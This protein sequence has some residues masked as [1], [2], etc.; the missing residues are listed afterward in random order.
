MAGAN[1]LSSKTGSAKSVGVVKKSS[2]Q[3]AQGAKWRP[4]M[5]VP[6]DVVAHLRMLR[7]KQMPR[8]APS[9]RR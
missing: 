5:P 1:G 3:S 6:D 2:A 8:A 4:G 7:G 9:Y